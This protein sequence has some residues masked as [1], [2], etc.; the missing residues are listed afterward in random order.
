MNKSSSW[1]FWPVLNTRKILSFSGFTII[2]NGLIPI[3]G[4][5]FF[6]WEVFPILM[7]YCIEVVLVI[8]DFGISLLLE[9]TREKHGIFL[10][11]WFLI[12]FLVICV[13]FAF[14]LPIVM[15]IIIAISKVENAVNLIWNVYFVISVAILCINIIIVS[16]I[17]KKYLSKGQSK[18]NNANVGWIMPAKAYLLLIC[19]GFIVYFN[20]FSAS[21]IIVAMLKMFVELRSFLRHPFEKSRIIVN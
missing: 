4:V 8:T 21:L 5:L 17:N 11:A 16:K 12:P 3:F 1:L 6:N 13:I 14:Y 20:L 10:P 19:T 18:F 9:T 7:F 2:L 15:I